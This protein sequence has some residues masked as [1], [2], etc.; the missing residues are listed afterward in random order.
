MCPKLI[1]CCARQGAQQQKRQQE[2]QLAK[3]GRLFEV[4]GK[5]LVKNCRAGVGCCSCLHS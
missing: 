3:G 5:Y 4:L 1:F 2:T